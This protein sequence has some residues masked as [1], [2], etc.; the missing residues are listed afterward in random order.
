MGDRLGTPG[1]VG[2]FYLFVW[3]VGFC[4]LC[5][6]LLCSAT[7]S[8]LSSSSARLAAP[9]SLPPYLQLGKKENLQVWLDLPRE[10]YHEGRR[11]GRP[12]SWRNRFEKNFIIKV[13]EDWLAGWQG[14]PSGAETGILKIFTSFS[15]LAAPPEEK[16]IFDGSE[17]QVRPTG[18]SL[19]NSF[20]WKVK[21]KPA[22][23][24]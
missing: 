24:L 22:R 17:G 19:N 1:A 23:G 12:V 13:F 18:P 16:T 3:L 6:A 8:L 10:I 14:C 4:L 21:D 15:R 2:C 9:T 5:F 11:H 20:E 7:L